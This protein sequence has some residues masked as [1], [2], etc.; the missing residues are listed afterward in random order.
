MSAFKQKE[1]PPSALEN[2]GRILSG[3]NGASTTSL[4]DIMLPVQAE[5]VILNIQFLVIEDLSSF[6]AIMGRT[7]LHGMKSIPSIYHQMSLTEIDLPTVDPLRFI[8]LS[9]KSDH[10]TYVISLL[11]L[12]ELQALER[13][14][15]RNKDVFA[16]THSDMP[17][18]HPS[19]ASYRLNVMPSSR[20]VHQKI[21]SFH[22]DK[23]KIIQVEVDKL[24]AVGFI[25][26]VEYPD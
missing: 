18:I 17:G 23:Q 14:L 5:P 6:N 10:F 26:E 3:F 9:K 16:W 1:F 19:I 21:R 7:W 4:G 12:G 24:L 25:K 11:E 8:H 15:H 2:L 22:P 20:P 13:V